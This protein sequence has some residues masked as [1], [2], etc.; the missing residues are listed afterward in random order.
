MR[1][2]DKLKK[3]NDL[4]KPLKPLG[5]LFLPQGAKKQFEFMFVA[6]M[7]SMNEPEEINDG[8]SFNFG[9]SAPDRFLQKLMT[10][11]K[12][13]GSYVTDIVKKRDKPRRPT[14]E[15]IMHWCP[16]LL[17]EIEII[18]PKYIIVIGKTN[19]ERN[20]KKFVEPRIPSS[21]KIDWVWHYS[22][23]GSKTNAEIEQ[24]FFDIVNKMR[25]GN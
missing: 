19:Y 3:L 8:E 2:D 6:E 9:V 24:K 4:N 10:E 18:R 17:E 11:N 7:P 15:E 25:I 23:Q 22:Q 20:F 21:I 16:I 13:S 14:E 1:I 12:V 5:G